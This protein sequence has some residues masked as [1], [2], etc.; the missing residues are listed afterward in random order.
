[1]DLW[2]VAGKLKQFISQTVEIG[3]KLR[4]IVDGDA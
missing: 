3:R 2:E 1:V 4:E